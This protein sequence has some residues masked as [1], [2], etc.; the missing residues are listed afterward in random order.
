MCVRITQYSTGAVYAEM[1]GWHAL[2]PAEC[3]DPDGPRYN[4]APGATPRI[5]HRQGFD[6]APGMARVHWG[7]T[8]AENT[9]RPPRTYTNARVETA[10]GSRTFG[11]LWRSGRCLVPVEGWYEWQGQSV[12]EQ[13]FRIRLPGDE[14]MFLAAITNFRPDQPV[15]PGSGFVLISAQAGNGLLDAHDRRPVVLAA[16]DALTWLKPE[17]TPEHARLLASELLLPPPAFEWYPVTTAINNT[18]VDRADL[19]KPAV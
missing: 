9:S 8:P 19:L 12:H 13:P 18:A 17:T 10:A 3:L 6:N 7:Y 15:L 16:E 14:P 4:I 2:P 5:L 11:E 1:L